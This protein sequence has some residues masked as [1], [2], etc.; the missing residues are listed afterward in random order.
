MAD[1]SR[2]GRPSVSEEVINEITECNE[3]GLL[4][5][6]TGCF[7]AHQI[8]L[9]TE[10]PYSTVRKVLRNKLKHRPYHLHMCHELKEIDFQPRLDFANW[11]LYREDLWER[12]LWT[13]EVYFYL[14]GNVCTKHCVI[15]TANNPHFASS[16]H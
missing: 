7:S 14:D 3:N 5:S 6:A 8:A 16:F 1:A 15:W 12:T 4:Q 10:I 13:D 9:A 2:S 11:F